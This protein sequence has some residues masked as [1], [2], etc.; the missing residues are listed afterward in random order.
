MITGSDATYFETIKLSVPQVS[1]RRVFYDAVNGWPK[2][3]PLVE[4][5]TAVLSIR[6]NPD[7]LLAGRLDESLREF[8][9]SAPGD[10]D[11]CAWHEAGNLPAYNVPPYNEW[12]TPETMTKVHVYM[13]QLCAATPN[14][15]GQKVSYGPILCMPPAG[16]KPWM[17]PGMDWYGLDIYDW[18]EFHVDGDFS[19]P[20]DIRGLLYPRL[21]QWKQV[22]QEVSGKS[23]AH[24]NITETNSGNPHHRP[25]WFTAVGDWMLENGGQRMLT[26][27]TSSASGVGP[28]L[29]D[30]EDTIRALR[31]L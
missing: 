22:V 15:H 1:C 12:I 2:H 4:G 26:F 6:P 18:P 23:F 28:W 29:P 24:L 25:K 27:W 5:T 31:A 10:N 7:D 30:D 9:A 3:W 11:L 20:L 13:Q 16:M 17:P 14:Q 21:D 19:K 8:I